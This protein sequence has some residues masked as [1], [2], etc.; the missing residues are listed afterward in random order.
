MHFAT[1]ALTREP[2]A[3]ANLL[4]LDPLVAAKRPN[5]GC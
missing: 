3:F 4:D 2:T 1:Y 5:P